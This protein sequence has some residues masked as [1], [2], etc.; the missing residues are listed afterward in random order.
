MRDRTQNRTVASQG[1]QGVKFFQAEIYVPF[2]YAHILRKGDAIAYLLV[3][4][5]KNIG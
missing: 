5:P 2:K 1:D 3:E 4:R